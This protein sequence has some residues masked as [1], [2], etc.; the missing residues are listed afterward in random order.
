M[1]QSRKETPATWS[2][3]YHLDFCIPATNFLDDEVTS[4]SYLLTIFTL[5]VYIFTTGAKTPTPDIQIC[6][7]PGCDTATSELRTIVLTFKR[8]S[9]KC[10]QSSFVISRPR[11]RAGPDSIPVHYPK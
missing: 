3:D 7:R 10:M 8:S 4:S 1:T 6:S 2:N 5:R 11:S 9:A